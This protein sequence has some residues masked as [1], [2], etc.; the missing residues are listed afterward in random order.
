MIRRAA[1][2]LLTIAL[3][4][5]G[6]SA[7]R[8]AAEGTVRTAS[9]A[10]AEVTTAGGEVPALQPAVEEASGWLAE[11]ERAVDLWGNAPRSLP[12]E[13]VAPCLARSLDDVRRA[14]TDAGREVPASLE[15]A[16]AEAAAVT[17]ATCPRR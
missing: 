6:P 13:T 15:S 14:L 7:E 9:A 17:D 1:P 8:V 16:Q 10:L 3:A 12:Y 2:L 5:C 4:A 11:A